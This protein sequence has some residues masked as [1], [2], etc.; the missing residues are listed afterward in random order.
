M[1]SIIWTFRH[2]ER[3]IAETRSNL[4]LEI[5]KKFQIPCRNSKDFFRGYHNPNIK[6]EGTISLIRDHRY[7]YDSN[8]IAVVM[9][10]RMTKVGYIEPS[11]TAVLSPLVDRNLILV[12]GF[13]PKFR[14]KKVHK[15]NDVRLGMSECEES[16]GMNMGDV[17]KLA[18]EALSKKGELEAME[19]PTNVIKSKLFQLQKEGLGG[20]LTGKKTMLDRSR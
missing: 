17:F 2:T 8:G 10:V 6:G 11:I 12:Q 9:K 20:W 3:N 16:G 15:Y 1:D 5:L 18:K 13:V 7:A 19:P 14:A 4:L